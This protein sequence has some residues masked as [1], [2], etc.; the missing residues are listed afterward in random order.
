MP[1]YVH[2]LDVDG[3]MGE[4]DRVPGGHAFVYPSDEEHDLNGRFHLHSAR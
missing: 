1:D 3:L 2:A 4:S